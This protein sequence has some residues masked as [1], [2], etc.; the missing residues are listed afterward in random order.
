MSRL[1][2]AITGIG[3]YVPDYV[4]TNKELEQMVDTNDEWIVTRTGIK[5]RR[6]LKIPETGSSFLGAKAVE[7]LL[8]KTNTDPSEI[9]LMICSTATPDMMFPDTA[10]IIADKLNIRNAFTFDLHAACSGFLFALTTGAKYV[11]SGLYKKVVIVGADKMSSIVDYTDRA[12]CILFGDGAGAALLEPTEEPI[13][14]IDSLLKSD[15]VGGRYLYQ[16]GGGSFHPATHETV[17]NKEHYIFQDGKPVFKAAI[18]GMAD[19]VTKVM[20]RNNLPADDVNWV[21]PHQAN[22]RI[23]EQVA[24]FAEFPM[25]RVMVNIHKY[26]NTTTATIPLCLWEYEKQLKKGDNLILTA[27]GGGFTWGAIYLKWAYDPQ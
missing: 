9:D 27:F 8:K 23:I 6:L 21:V 1:H 5:E 20:G 12:T 22:L 7:E 10:N 26:G 13:G 18:E 25:E 19:V 3:G 11:E 14:V 2:A 15:G 4:L 24:R 17:N 16:R